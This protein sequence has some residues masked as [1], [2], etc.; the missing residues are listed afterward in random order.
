MRDV[1]LAWFCQA[2]GARLKAFAAIPRQ[3]SPA[4]KRKLE[5]L[6]RDVD[7]TVDCDVDCTLCLA[8]GAWDLKEERRKKEEERSPPRSL[9]HRID[10]WSP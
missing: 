5:A 4:K 10:W 7:C 2:R 8:I 1:F 6:P 3:T 9:T